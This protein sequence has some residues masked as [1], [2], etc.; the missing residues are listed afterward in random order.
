MDAVGVEAAD[1][2]DF[3]DLDHAD[4]AAGRGGQVEVA[5]GLAEYEVAGFVGF[6]RLD[7]AEVGE[8]AALEDVLFRSIW[9]VERFRFLALGDLGADAGLGVES[10]NARAA[11]AHPLGERALR[12]EFDLELPGEVL[13]LELLVLADVGADHLL[14]LLGAQQ[15]ADAFVVDAGVVAGKRE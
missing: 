15:L 9:A 14:D 10:G 6:P 5:R 8:N 4:L 11:R 1:R 3:L 13:A 2:H 12:A 7:D